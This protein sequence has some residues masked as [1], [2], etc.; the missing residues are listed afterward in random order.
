VVLPGEI[1]RVLIMREG[2]EHSQ[3]VGYLDDGTMVVVEGARKFINRTID[4]TVTTLH[5][6]TAGKMIF[7]RYDD[8]GESVGRATSPLASEAPGSEAQNPSDQ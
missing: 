7:A 1:M 3:G 2:K 6:T 4:I 8:P 5:Q